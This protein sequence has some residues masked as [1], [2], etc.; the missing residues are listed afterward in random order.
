VF[1]TGDVEAGDETAANGVAVDGW[2]TSRV[3]P[4]RLKS[5]SVRKIAGRSLFMG[6]AVSFR[7]AVF[8]MRVDRFVPGP[9]R[10]ILATIEEEHMDQDHYERDGADDRQHFIPES[11]AAG[12]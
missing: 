2:L 11:C 6:D 5:I 10:F 12:M 7:S 1:G 9:G 4:K 3:Q 8:I